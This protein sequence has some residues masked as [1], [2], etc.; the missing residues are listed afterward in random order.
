MSLGTTDYDEAFLRCQ[1][2]NLRLERPWRRNIDGRPPD[3]LT[4]E[5]ISALAGIVFDEAVAAQRAN[6]GRPLKREKALRQ[7]QA[8]QRRDWHIMPMVQHLR[9]RF[10]DEVAAFLARH[11]LHLVDD[12]YELFIKAFVQAAVQASRSSRRRSGFGSPRMPR[13]KFCFRNFFA[14]IP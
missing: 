7:L 6:P 2:E 5:Q 4:Q 14:R 11:D 9:V 12:T 10:G 3:Q 13:W 1:E 8:R